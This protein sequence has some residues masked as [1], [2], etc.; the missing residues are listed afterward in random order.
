MQKVGTALKG[1][2]LGEF[3]AWALDTADLWMFEHTLGQSAS[4]AGLA[5]AVIMTKAA[6]FGAAK[7][8]IAIRGA[9]G[10]GKLE[11]AESAPDL[12]TVATRLHEVMRTIAAETGFGVPSVAELVKQ[13][14]AGRTA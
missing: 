7:A 1:L 3:P 12:H 9:M 6:A 5:G 4:Q 14:V 10:K 2:A 8:W 13:M 11:S